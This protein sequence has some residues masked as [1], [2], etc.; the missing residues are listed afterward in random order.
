VRAGA[1]DELGEAF[2]AAV[3]AMDLHVDVAV[4]LPD[5]RS[6]RDQVEMT[7]QVQALVVS[8]T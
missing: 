8:R 2:A 6:Y 7:S 5:P 3:E 4:R 1:G